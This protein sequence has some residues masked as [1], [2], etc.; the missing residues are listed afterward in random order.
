MKYLAAFS[1]LAALTVAALSACGSG[2]N[3]A[4]TGGGT[5]TGGTGTGGDGGVSAGGGTGGG[6]SLDSGTGATGNGGYTGDA[7][8]VAASKPGEPISAPA[9]IIWAVD[10][11][12]SMNQETAYVQQKINDFANQI[13]G[14]N[15]DYHVVMIAQTTGGNAICVP[16]PLSGGGCGDG[17]RFRL[18]N[19]YVDSNDALDRIID[20]YPKYQDFLRIDAV[21]HFVVVSD[22][23]PTDSPI[24]SAAAFTGAIANLQPPGM[25]AKWK[26]H[27]IFA[28]GA[29]PVVGCIGVFGTGALY[30]TI[31]E[32]LVNADRRSSGRDLPGRLDAGLRRYPKRGGAGREGLVRIRR[33]RSRRRADPRSDEGQRPVLPG[34]ATSA[35]NG[36]PRELSE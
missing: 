33:A 7:C 35:P 5:S 16:P 19:Q 26:F 4:G 13:A 27:S 28:F 24:N 14:S 29:I 3:S 20:Q 9:D 17:P 30:G 15:I 25:F 11:S 36:L 18:V 6:I 12:G 32:Q 21:K 22:D 10:Q 2:D 8:A 23:N 1:G 34:R 31:L